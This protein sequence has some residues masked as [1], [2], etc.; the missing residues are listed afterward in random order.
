MECKSSSWC[1]SARRAK[2]RK[3]PDGVQKLKLVPFGKAG[4]NWKFPD[5]VQ[6]LKLV[7]FGKT[8]P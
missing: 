5:G 7:P 1:P 4:K 2:I 8:S 3:F 6:K